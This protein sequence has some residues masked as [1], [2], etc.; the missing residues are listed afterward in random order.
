MKESA[1]V[2]VVTM[3]HFPEKNP[4]EKPVVPREQATFLTQPA[5][6][7]SR[8]TEPGAPEACHFE[9]RTFRQ[10]TNSACR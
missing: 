7:Q 8:V 2:E 5:G 10:A 6:K 4:G 1:Q 9:P 3:W